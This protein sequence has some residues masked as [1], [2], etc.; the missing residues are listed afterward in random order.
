MNK[1]INSVLVE[2]IEAE[3]AQTTQNNYYK[4]ISIDE[5]NLETKL[6]LDLLVEKY[7]GYIYRDDNQVTLLINFSNLAPKNQT[8]VNRK[9]Y[10][11]LTELEQKIDTIDQTIK[12][13]KDTQSKNYFSYM[14]YF[15][16]VEDVKHD[17]RQLQQLIDEVLKKE[18]V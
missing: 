9:L 1:P 17:S 7:G 3:I 15:N 14:G 2:L 13:F 8:K 4:T 12:E 6:T 5:Y 11:K 16:P 18:E 10:Q